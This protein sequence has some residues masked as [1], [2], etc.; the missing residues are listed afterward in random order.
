MK[1]DKVLFLRSPCCKACIPLS[2]RTIQERF[3]ENEILWFVKFWDSSVT[4]EIGPHIGPHRPTHRPT[5]RS[6][7]ARHTETTR[8]WCRQHQWNVL[9]ILHTQSKCM[10]WWT[11]SA[12]TIVAATSTARLTFSGNQ[13]TVNF[14][15][16]PIKKAGDMDAWLCTREWSVHALQTCTAVV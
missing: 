7:S 9:I 14:N 5:Y 11:S 3:G 16:T 2:K 1:G 15:K 10:R 8:W 4:A 6:T 13:S 12:N